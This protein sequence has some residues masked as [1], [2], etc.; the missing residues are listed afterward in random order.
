M[1]CIVVL[2]RNESPKPQ[3]PGE[4]E[5]RPLPQDSWAMSAKPWPQQT[6]EHQQ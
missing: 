2:W 3:V 1:S 4:M 6:P 5:A